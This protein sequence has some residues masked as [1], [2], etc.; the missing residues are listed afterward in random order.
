MTGT[1]VK[2]AAAVFQNPVS[3]AGKSAKGPAS[4]GDFDFQSVWNNQMGKSPQNA[5]GTQKPAQKPAS[6]PEKQEQ[7]VEK[8]DNV[9]PEEPR[10]TGDRVESPKD[11][12]QPVKTDKVS[13][14]DP[15]QSAEPGPEELEAAMEVLG[16]AAMELMQK[17]ADAFG[18]SM[19]ELQGALKELGMEPL[20]LLQPA[21]LAEMVLRLGGAQDSLALLTDET[22]CDNYKALMGQMT[23]VLNEAAKELNT[24]PKQ[25]EAL[26]GERLAE[27]QT[28]EK[29]LAD[30]VVQEISGEKVPEETVSGERASD[31]PRETGLQADGGAKAPDSLTEDG[32]RTEVNKSDGAGEKGGERQPQKEDDGGQPG[33]LFAQEL[34]PLQPETGVQQ[35]QGVSQSTVWNADTQDIMRQIMDYMKLQLNADTTNLEMHLH[36]ASLGTLHIQVEAKAGVITASFIA[37]NEAVK[38]AL[39]SQ[40]VQ[41]RESFEEQGVKVE[42]IEVM[43]QS[44]AFERNLEQGREQSQGGNEPSKKARVRRINLNDL[45]DMDDMEEE[46]ALAADMLAAGGSTVDYTA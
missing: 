12:S 41:L 38:A 18:I 27:E 7:P 17:I 1:A 24:D 8:Q 2:N 42:A 16:A 23:E 5:A 13:S 35:A 28:G 20:E 33:N 4:S 34:K 26:L 6:G 45:S 31:R 19:E 9:K 39:E 30:A 22:L 37:Q 15:G 29:P 10:E 21:G 40:I 36:P 25:L 3:S 32:L 43:V 14:E 44:H 46:D 11:G